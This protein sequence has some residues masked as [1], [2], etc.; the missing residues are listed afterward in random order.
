MASRRGLQMLCKNGADVNIRDL[1]G[2]TPL[3]LAVSK[4][5]R[6]SHTTQ[7]LKR[8]PE[9]NTADLR[10]KRTALQVLGSAVGVE[11]DG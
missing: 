6:V 11:R 7:L 10:D 4:D 9:L 2:R 8:H 3:W 5:G 1:V